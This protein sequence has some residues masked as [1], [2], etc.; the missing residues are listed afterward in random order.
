MTVEELPEPEHEEGK[1]CGAPYNQA[2]KARYRH[3]RTCEKQIGR[4]RLQNESC[5]HAGYC[6]GECQQAGDR[7]HPNLAKPKLPQPK[8]KAVGEYLKKCG[9]ERMSGMGRSERSQYVYK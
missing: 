4:P 7:G 1:P 8:I 2:D 5:V 6:R 9:C 3:Q